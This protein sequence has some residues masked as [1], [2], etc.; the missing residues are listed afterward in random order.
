MP[1]A[2]I[3]ITAANG[4][5]MQVKTDQFWSEVYNQVKQRF[6]S[7]RR[8]IYLEADGEKEFVIVP[9]NFKKIQ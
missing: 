3:E 9:T 5:K 7:E 2:T 8:E 4:R 1:N 6:E